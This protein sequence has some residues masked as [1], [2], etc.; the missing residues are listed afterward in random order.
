VAQLEQGAVELG[1]ALAPML[2]HGAAPP[3]LQAG[4]A[5][6]LRVL[7]G[8]GPRLGNPGTTLASGVDLVALE[9]RSVVARGSALWLTR[10]TDSTR[11]YTVVTNLSGVRSGDVL[12]AAF[13]PP[14]EVGGEVSEAM[15]LGADRR[16]EAAGTVL[17]EHDADAREVATI[18]HD[19]LAHLR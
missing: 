4:L 6:C 8:L 9:V 7:S 18:L 3:L 2:A 10:A 19:E 13:L 17:S 5:W 15:Y 14:R 11:D 12:G 1:E 16:G